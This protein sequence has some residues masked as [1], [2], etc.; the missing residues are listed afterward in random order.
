MEKVFFFFYLNDLFKRPLARM[1]HNDSSRNNNGYI[2]YLYNSMYRKNYYIYVI[3]KT[4]IYN[5]YI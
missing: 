1:F 5:I 4:I 3:H 2:R